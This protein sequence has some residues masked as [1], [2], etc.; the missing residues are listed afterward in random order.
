MLLDA[1]ADGEDVGVEDDVLWSE[2]GDIGEQPVGAGRD[3]DATL[4]ALRLARLVEGHDDRRGAVAADEPGVLEEGRLA[5]LEAD[6]VH[7]AAALEALEA[8]LDDV[9]P[10]VSSMIGTAL[11]SGS[12]ASSL[13]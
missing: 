10:T 7:D 8:G 13:R 2:P 1:G 4:R 9:P 6:R 12:D 5:L 3:L 11:M